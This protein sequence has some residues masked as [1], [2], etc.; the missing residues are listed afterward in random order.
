M[1]PEP[2][3]ILAV[4]VSLAGMTLTLL[5]RLDR[6]IDRL[7]QGLLDGLRDTVAGRQAAQ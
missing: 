5:G 6:R 4:G 1:S 3:A 7:E 2:I